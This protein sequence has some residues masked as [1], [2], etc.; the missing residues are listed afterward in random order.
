MA[1]VCG[2]LSYWSGCLSVV[3]LIMAFLCVPVANAT[4]YY[5]CDQQQGPTFG[6]LNAGAACLNGFT[7]GLCGGAPSNNQI[8]T[9]V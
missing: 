1:K 3:V 9:C 6:C 8:C 5:H 4:V 7:P 2:I